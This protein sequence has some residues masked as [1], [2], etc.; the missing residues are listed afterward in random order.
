M[1]TVKINASILNVRQTPAP[2]APVVTQLPRD[3]AVEKVGAS[4]DGQWFQVRTAAGTSGWISAKYAVDAAPAE[5]PAQW[6]SITASLLNLRAA[7]E[8]AA[9]VLAK[10]PQ[11]SRVQKLGA[12]ADGQWFQVRAADGNEGWVSAQYA[13]EASPAPV[14][15]PPGADFPWLV[16]ARGE[17]G[18]TEIEGAKNNARIVEYHAATSLKASDDET[19]WCSAFVN[20]CM[21]QAGIKG[22]GEANARSWLSWG[23]A[24]SEPVRG[25]V[26]VLTRGGST[27]SG[28][29]GFYMGPNGDRIQ[30]LGGNQSNSVK[31]SNY[32]TADILGYRLPAS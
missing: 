19:P 16:I 29:V 2:D 11:G 30:V 27:T 22:S 18:Q 7:A 28:H 3:T 15:P 32:P 23:R 9:A 25:C 12:S 14:A 24:V 20:W 10:L 5:P 13:V 8:S 21:K 4:D 31:L 6:L 1:P 26:V 17:I